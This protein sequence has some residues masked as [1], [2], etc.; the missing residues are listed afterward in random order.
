MSEISP[1]VRAQI[2]ATP[3][4]RE[5]P[6]IISDA[7]EVLVAFMA[8]FERYLEDQGFYFDWS[9]FRLTGAVRRQSDRELLPAEEVHAALLG[10]YADCTEKLEPVPG[11]VEA[12]AALNQ[13]AQVVV[14]SNLP[15]E[16]GAARRRALAAQG[17]AYPLIVNEGPKGPAVRLLAGSVDAPVFFLDDSPNHLKSVA[18][19]ARRCIEAMSAIEDKIGQ[20]FY[21]LMQDFTPT[22][23][24]VLTHDQVRAILVVVRRLKIRLEVL[25]AEMEKLTKKN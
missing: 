15:A 6:L 16:H 2:E 12:L 5:R 20:D 21:E 7:D 11:A 3:L 14:L 1:D 22:V 9:G 19:H 17:M 25:E 24:G 18:D 4:V 13:R 10:F 8:A 23:E